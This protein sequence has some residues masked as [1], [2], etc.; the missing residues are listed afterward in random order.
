MANFLKYVL[1]LTAI[2]LLVGLNLQSVFADKIYKWTDSKGN[3]HYSDRP[4]NKNQSEQ[5]K[6]APGPSKDKK[7]AALQRQQQLKS[8]ADT[9]EQDNKQRE[10]KRAEEQK[11]LDKKLAAE[12]AKQNEVPQGQN[13]DNYGYGRYPARRPPNYPQPPP[14]NYPKPGKPPVVV[15]LPSGANPGRAR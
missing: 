15:P 1:S 4:D 13:T 2:F 12:K 7:D 14:S 9:L 6:I 8:T 5:I 10:Q 11:E 3:I